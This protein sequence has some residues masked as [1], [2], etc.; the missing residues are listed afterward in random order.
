VSKTFFMQKPFNLR[1]AFST[2][3]RPI[4]RVSMRFIKVSPLS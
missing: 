4:P 3:A 2:L 1:G